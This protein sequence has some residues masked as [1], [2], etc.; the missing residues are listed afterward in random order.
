VDFEVVALD[1][2]DIVHVESARFLGPVLK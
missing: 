1:N 2:P